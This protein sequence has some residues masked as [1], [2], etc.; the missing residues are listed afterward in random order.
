MAILKRRINNK[1]PLDDLVLREKVVDAP[2]PAPLPGFPVRIVH[3]PNHRILLLHD[4][5]V[6]LAL[7]C[8]FAAKSG[9]DAWVCDFEDSGLPARVEA[10]RNK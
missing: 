4:K 8:D 5:F 1:V 3:G 9:C 6:P 2:A 10:W 7:I